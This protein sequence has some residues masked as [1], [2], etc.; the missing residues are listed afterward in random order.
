MSTTGNALQQSTTF[1][2]SAS[3]LISLRT[4]IAA[5]AVLIGLEC[6][7]IQIPRVMLFNEHRPL[8]HVQATDSFLHHPGLIDILLRSTLAVNVCAGVRRIGEHLMDRA[9]CRRN[10]LDSRSPR[11]LLG[12]K[13]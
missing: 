2:H 6:R 12:G 4:N 5:D 8:L 1:S 13:A 7:P 9:V 11:V 10:P 3:R